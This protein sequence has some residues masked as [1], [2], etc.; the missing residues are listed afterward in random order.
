MTLN[1]EAELAECQV[2]EGSANGAGHSQERSA[3]VLRWTFIAEDKSSDF[4]YTENWP[5]DSQA[6]SKRFAQA[7]L[8]AECA[9]N[10]W[11]SRTLIPTNSTGDAT[12]SQGS[13]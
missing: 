13:D 11:M 2:Q 4:R 1:L 10:E 7:L 6:T 5:A 3:R 8:R 9:R 12:P